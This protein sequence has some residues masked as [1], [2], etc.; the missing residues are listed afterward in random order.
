MTAVQL[1]VAAARSAFPAVSSNSYI[2]ADNAGGSQ[3]LRAVAERVTDYL[4]NTNVQLGADYSVSVISTN[5]VAEGVEAAR[6]LLNAASVDEV[7]FGGS[8]SM[9]AENL[10]RA[11]EADVVEG[12]EIIVTGEHEANAGPWKRLASRR[13]LTIKVWN[14]TPSPKTPNNPYSVSLHLETLLPLITSKTRLVAFTAC[15]NILGSIVPVKKVIAAI[16]AKAR[17]VGARK[18]ETSVDCVAYAPHRRIDVQDWGVDYCFFSVY[19]VY[20]AHLSVLYT[21]AECIKSSLSSLTHHFL[22]Y[23]N[24]SLKL[25]PGGTGYELVYSTTAVPEYLKSLSSAGTLEA[26]FELIAQHEQTLIRPLLT[27]LKSKESRGVRIVGEESADP[28]RVPTVSFVVV[29]PQ[30]KSSKEIVRTFDQAGNIGIRYG[31]FYAYTL[32][33][34]LEPKIDL[35]DAIVRISLVHYNTVEEVEKIIELLDLALV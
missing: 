25:Q 24:S 17:E 3:C 20:G 18:V 13:G 22:S 26:G 16:K 1:D 10:S 14:A 30:K 9:L 34:G 31:H 2:F 27:Y 4:L 5:R 6:Q 11:L 7:A 35:A 19:K 15:S 8:S 29:G 28:S 21:R 23:D 12:E 33:E 32:I